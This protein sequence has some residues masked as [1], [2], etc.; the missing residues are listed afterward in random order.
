MAEATTPAR[1]EDVVAE[2]IKAQFVS[3][4][5]D[6]QFKNMVDRAIADFTQR[7]GYKKDSPSEL[8]KIIQRILHKH[9]A[10]QVEALLA[11]EEYA[12]VWGTPV[13]ASQVV[14]DFLKDLTPEIIQAQ[15][16]SAYQILVTRIQTELRSAIA[17]APRTF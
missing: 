14:K 15:Y 7:T 6:D 13:Q 8:E 3:L 9:F 4:I 2:R 11:S 16:A 10:E 1:I 12:P 17:N 5:P